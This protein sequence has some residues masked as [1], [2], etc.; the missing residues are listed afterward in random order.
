MTP[1]DGDPVADMFDAHAAALLLYARQ[2][3]AAAAAEDVVQ[4]VFV[5]LVAGGRL[6][7]EPR[8]WLFRCVRNEAIAAWRSDRRRDCRERAAA[9]SRRAAS[10]GQPGW[11]VAR[12]DDRLDAATA[13]AALETLPA[14]QREAVVLRLWSGLTLKEIAAVTGCGVTTAHDR[15]HA[16]LAALRL[17]L[18]H[19]CER[20]NR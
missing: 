9:A 13:Q 3:V 2:W 8:T 19:P 12:P 18:E 20:T 6:P 15:Y 14:D 10:A 11:F 17:R 5:R 7:A 4:R 1:A 16:A